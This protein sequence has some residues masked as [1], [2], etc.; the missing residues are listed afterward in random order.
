LQNLY[1]RL[2]PDNFCAGSSNSSRVSAACQGKL[3]L[4]L[5][6]RV[7]VAAILVTVALGQSAK[8]SASV[9]VNIASP[10]PGATVAS[11]VQF[12]ASA[13]APAG[14]VIDAMRIYVDSQD[15][16][17]VDAASIN[18]ALSLGTGAHNINV[19]AWDNT[20][21]VYVKTMNIKVGSSGPYEQ[22]FNATSQ[23]VSQFSQPDGAILYVPGQI[24]PYFANIGAIGMTKDPN[25]MPEVVAWMNWYVGHLNWP[26]KWGLYGTMYDYTVS[27]G[28][29]TPTYTADST[30]SYAA[31][32]LTLAW[33]AW[34]SGDANARS[35]ISSISYQLDVI[36]G[37]L[38]Q[39]QQS[40]G[41]TW[42]RPDYEI[43]YLMDNSEGYRG[44]S[45]LASL[46]N[47]LG[48]SAKSSYYTAAAT[49]MQNGILSMWMNGNWA[50]Y[51]NWYGQL[52]APNMGTWYADASSQVFPVLMGVVKS[53]D[54]RAQQAYA[55]LNAAWPG[56][57]ELSFNSQDPFPWCLVVDGAAA[58]GDQARVATYIN[59]V[60]SQYV[61]S[62]FP[63]PF[64]N[65]EAGWFIRANN[66]M[67]GR[68]L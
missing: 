21:A 34:K 49:S 38:I 6:R 32:F 20:G 4:H 57:P 28:V 41:L 36:G 25:R 45:D 14:R 59:T 24:E 16:Y 8:L 5:L 23:W 63:W 68:G 27:N 22:N 47:A 61:N 3:P 10:S 43:K 42:A 60:Q 7:A 1:F 39:T 26:D 53:S 11:P 55:A 52:I 50:V 58:M 44:L 15:A 40:D 37:V 66:Y 46:F 65:A 30:D 62:G 19:Q 9:G 51:K 35:Y 29:E 33:N 17:T 56:W 2:L 13:T 64:Y 31:T 54:S 18:T 12:A 48:D 67:L